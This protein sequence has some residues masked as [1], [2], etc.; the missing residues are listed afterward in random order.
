MK[1]NKIHPKFQFWTKI[2][3]KMTYLVFVFCLFFI[4]SLINSKT[5]ELPQ[6][7]G[8]LCEHQIFLREGISPLN[9]NNN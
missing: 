6:S 3:I 1:I 7:L 8:Y 9:P 4:H 5:S 2:E